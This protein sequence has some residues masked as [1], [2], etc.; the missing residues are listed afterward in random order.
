M[1]AMDAAQDAKAERPRG[2]LG[3]SEIGDECARRL[4]YKWREFGQDK[5]S[6][7]A[8]RIFRHGHDVEDHVVELLRS[9]P[10]VQ[11]L[12]RD[13]VTRR[14][15]QDVR[16]GGHVKSHFDGFLRAPGILPTDAWYILEIKSMNDRRWKK[17]RDIGVA[18]SDPKYYAQVQSYLDSPQAQQRGCQ[19]AVFLA[20]NKNTADLEGEIVP[21]EPMAALSFHGVAQG[22]V[23]AAEPPPRAAKEPE[24]VTCRFCVFKANGICWEGTPSDRSSCRQC[25]FGHADTDTGH[26]VCSNPDSPHSG[27]TSPSP[28][29]HFCPFPG[30]V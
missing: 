29:V 7:K 1:S 19:A 13:P 24:W 21:Y 16:F 11:I 9:T 15:F 30:Q 17:W 14:Q 28:C 23:T 25:R 6:A 22:I 20:L 27:H 4:W 18:Q 26:W 5:P 12:D 2:Y 3:G 10:G 8:K